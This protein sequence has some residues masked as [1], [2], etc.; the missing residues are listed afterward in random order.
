MLALSLLAIA[1]AMD[2]FAV[3][4]SLGTRLSQLS[5]DTAAISSTLTPLAFALKIALMA[6]VY[7]G[8][9]QAL[10]PVIGY[11][12]GKSLLA[13]IANYGNWIAC[14][15]LCVLGVRMLLEALD[16]NKQQA[17]RNISPKFMFSLAVATSIDAMAAGFTLNLLPINAYVACAIIGITTFVFSFVGVFIGK[18]TGHILESKAE[19]LGGLVLIG[20]GINMVVG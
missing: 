11:V 4:I 10:M 14:V 8:V 9:F 16:D 13:F 17:Q 19:V 7:F 6:G 20:I 15:I 18:K 12:L 2:A 5:V 3:A 1:L